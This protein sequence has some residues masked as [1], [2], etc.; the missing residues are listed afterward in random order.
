M[1]I[2]TASGP[3]ALALIVFAGALALRHAF[4]SDMIPVVAWDQEPRSLWALG[5]AFLLCSIQYISLVV[6]ALVVV[7]TLGQ[8][9]DQ[10]AVQ[11]LHVSSRN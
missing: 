11:P 2:R 7:A 3:V 1:S 9:S 5:A 6:G 8:R 10:Q 4:L